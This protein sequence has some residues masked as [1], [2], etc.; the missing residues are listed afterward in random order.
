MEPHKTSKQILAYTPQRV[1]QSL[2]L[3]P[4]FPSGDPN[5]PAHTSHNHFTGLNSGYI[6]TSHLSSSEMPNSV[7]N[8]Q[9][10]SI[11]LL[12]GP[13]AWLHTR[14]GHRPPGLTH[15]SHGSN[16]HEAEYELPAYPPHVQSRSINHVCSREASGR[17]TKSK[18]KY[19]TLYSS[20]RGS[21]TF[22]VPPDIKHPKNPNIRVI[23]AAWADAPKTQTSGFYQQHGPT[24]RLSCSKSSNLEIHE[25]Q[26]MPPPQLPAG[27]RLRSGSSRR[28]ERAEVCET[29]PAA[30]TRNHLKFASSSVESNH[31]F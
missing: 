3:P 16:K 24:L 23:S 26:H 18:R 17:L 25:P 2:A 13:A 21:S 31:R 14:S 28:L 19:A 30:H 22:P 4:P 29:D 9:T 5:R 8:K 27:C 7:K 6:A 11:A 1:Q 15:G 20:E 12:A 10:S